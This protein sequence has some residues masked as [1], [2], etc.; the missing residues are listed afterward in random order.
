VTVVTPALLSV[1]GEIETFIS[2]ELYP[3]RV[4]LTVVA[5]LVLLGG[6]Y[7][8]Y[9]AGLHRLLW[10]HR[11]A[12]TL[13]GVPTL[14]VVAIVGNYLLSPLWER[15][16]ANEAPPVV[17]AAAPTAVAP[18][19]GS[20]PPA[21]GSDSAAAPSPVMEPTPVAPVAATEGIVLRGEFVG[22]DDFHFGEGTALIIETAPGQYVLRFEAFSVRNGPDLYVYVSP[23]PVDYAEA[24][25][26]VG[27]LKATDGAFNYE[28]PAGFSLDQVRS[29]IVWCKQF[30][31]LFAYA[32][33]T[34]A[35]SE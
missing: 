28:L 22:A 35:A 6:L 14:I 31:T 12:T 21:G 24:A 20:E 3:Y 8:A 27:T 11:L 9:R 17:Q 29:A 13:V 16:Y 30:S 4:P 34:P 1:F 7:A 2:E 32:T 33:L 5:V 18:G 10:R 23:D 15:S 25:Y 26:E 19:T